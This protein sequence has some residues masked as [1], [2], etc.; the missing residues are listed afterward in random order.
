MV[1]THFPQRIRGRIL[2][3]FF[4]SA[5]VG[6][7]LGAYTSGGVIASL[8]GWHAGF[9]LVGVPGL[10]LALLYLFVPTAATVEAADAAN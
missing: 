8:F 3:G 9:G 4:A 5:S 10:V 2:G 6:S 1:A 7:V